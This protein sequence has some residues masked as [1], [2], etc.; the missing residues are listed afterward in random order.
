MN[1]LPIFTTSGMTA[2]L[3]FALAYLSREWIKTRLQESIAHEYKK[4]LEEHKE[5]IQWESRRREQATQI[6]ELISLWVV[7]SYDKTRDKNMDRYQIQK[8]YWELALWLEPSVL[9]A[10]NKAFTG[11]PLATLRYREALITVRKAIV[12][13]TDDIRPEELVHWNPVNDPAEQGVD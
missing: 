6:A 10:L 11:D 5:S 9:R 1:L 13:G 2:I 3:L 8:K 7:G 4:A 12:G